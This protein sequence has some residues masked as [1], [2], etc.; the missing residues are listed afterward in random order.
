MK[1]RSPTL[2]GFQTLFRLPA[3]G[4]TE[5]VWRWSF[6]LAV[7]A[8]LAFSFREYMATLPV[9]AGEMFLL[10]TRQPALVLQALARILQGSA[11][12]VVATLIV[13]ALALTLA[14]VVLASVGRAAI[15]KTLFEYFRESDE[16]KSRTWWFTSLVA[17][18]FLRAGVMFAAV[19]AWVGAMLLASTASSE[20]DPSPGSALLI[21]WMLTLFTGLAWSTLNWFL[22]LAAI[23]VVGEGRTT[24]GALTA[25]A[26][27]CRNRPAPMAAAATWFGVAHT[28][29]F[30]IASSVA[31]FPLGFVEVLPAGMVLGGVILVTLIYFA[32][33][34]FLYVSRLAAYVFL[35]EVPE[36]IQQS[37]P[38]IQA[39]ASPSDDDIL[40]DIPGLT[41]PPQPATG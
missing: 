18:N 19:L 41:P 2:E 16:A 15:L 3:L 4:L 12:R 39:P 6:G 31:A 35:I 30:V 34:D 23:F 32:F 7:T 27:L 1:R 26:D 37:A 22:S 10:R 5:I 11:A 36:S 28:V 25:A 9:T 38:S 24:F 14:W 13:L 17:L 21:F 29:A 20:T 40:S 8:L 33:A